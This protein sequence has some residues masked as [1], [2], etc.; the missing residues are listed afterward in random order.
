MI[1]D[2]G[3]G[4][5]SGL[6]FELTKMPEDDKK[7]NLSPSPGLSPAGRSPVRR[8]GDELVRRMAAYGVLH[9]LWKAGDR[10]LV[11]VSS[12]ADSVA[13]LHLLRLL[14]REM[15]FELTVV[16]LDH[17]L[18][19][20]AAR[21]DRR[22]VEELASRLELPCIAARREVGPVQETGGYS[23]EEAARRV[24]YDFFREVSRR[25]GI[26]VLALGH[27][28]DD[29]A[30]TV[31]LRLLR[32]GRPAAL[33]G[34]LPAR[35][36][37]E[38][39]LVRPLLAFRREDLLAFLDEIGEEFR[40][41]LSN[42]DLSFLRNRVR[43]RLL[44]LLEKEYSPRC[45]ELLV[46]LAEREREREGYLR[47]RLDERCRELF[48][49][50]AEGP[51]LACGR[52]LRAAALERGEAL[53]YLL[54]RGGVSSPHRRHFRALERLAAG[55]SGRRLDLP[56]PVSARREGDLLVISLRR[57]AKTLPT[58]PLE[59][60]GERIIEP[61]SSRIQVRVYPAPPDLAFRRRAG[62][63]EA[64]GS[65]PWREYLDRERVVPPLVV[66]SRL[67]GDRYR[68]LGMEGRKKVK[69]ILIEAGVPLSRRGLIPVVADRERII[70]LAGH[71]PNHHCRVRED[72]REILEI[73]LEPLGRPEEKS[74]ATVDP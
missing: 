26:K 64:D 51:A 59:I 42:R 17:G 5:V 65:G 14:G 58:L 34:M 18:R 21:E 43:H 16:H 4:V 50:T 56:G 12:G 62:R 36:E 63:A 8:R 69:K 3:V 33:A 60:P 67:P 30:E 55:P 48:R 49:R 61:L 70:W 57:E 29:Q 19:G 46:E 1:C 25:T 52:F 7:K 38:L 27:Q 28:A 73:T 66:R 9:R 41:D 6:E 47:G 35:R 68:P 24:R 44:P 37:G 11:A 72:T 10:I 32:G 71:R 53:R 2:A 40:R 20:K 74:F 13:L 22:W 39:L 23:P 31:L 15:N 45:R 54:A